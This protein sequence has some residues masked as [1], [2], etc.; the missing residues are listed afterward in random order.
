MGVMT[1]P[2]HIRAGGLICCPHVALAVSNGQ[3]FAEALHGPRKEFRW[4][5]CPTCANVPRSLFSGVASSIENRHSVCVYCFAEWWEI[6][7]SN[8]TATPPS[9]WFH[10]LKTKTQDKHS[11]QDE[12]K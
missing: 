4:C 12:P 9:E 8:I 1:C 10:P 6:H 7:Q 3:P 11:S 5:A 2:K